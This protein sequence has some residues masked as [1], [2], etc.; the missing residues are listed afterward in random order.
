MCVDSA[1]L[2]PGLTDAASA[3]SGFDTS[4]KGLEFGRCD[5][6]RMGFDDAL[7]HL[8]WNKLDQLL[9][10]GHHAAVRGGVCVH[11]LALEQRWREKHCQHEASR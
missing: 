3:C 9:A 6:Y 5:S 4:C 2:D 10:G 8:F 7:A 1:W 11:G